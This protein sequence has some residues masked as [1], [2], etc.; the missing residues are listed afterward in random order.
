M[1]YDEEQ[2]SNK[3][4]FNAGIAQVM[5]LDKLQQAM[6]A[7]R[8]NLK[9]INMETGTYNYEC[10]INAAK[11][12]FDEIWPKLSDKEKKEGSSLIKTAEDIIRYKSPYESCSNKGETKHLF[13]KKSYENME[14]LIDIISRRLR[15]LMDAHDF[16]SPSKDEDDD[17]W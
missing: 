14:D 12:A 15:E 7:A 16:N 4:L 17:D 8:F 9:A 10:F 2:G 11:C 3:S 6:N 5:R 13:N 1:A